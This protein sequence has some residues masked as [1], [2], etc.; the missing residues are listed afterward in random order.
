[1][2]GYFIGAHTEYPVLG[3]GEDLPYLVLKLFDLLSGIG[4]VESRPDTSE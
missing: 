1:M 3:W 2:R 4:W